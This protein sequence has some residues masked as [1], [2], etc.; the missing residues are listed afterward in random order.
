M[1][2]IIDDLCRTRYTNVLKQVSKYLN[3]KYDQESLTLQRLAVK[4][5]RNDSIITFVFS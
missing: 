5:I 2:I 4:T 3:S 1:L